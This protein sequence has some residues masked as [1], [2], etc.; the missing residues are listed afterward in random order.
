M[1]MYS[2]DPEN[3]VLAS[4]YPGANQDHLYEAAY[5]HRHKA[6]TICDTCST[7]LETCSMSCDELQ[8]HKDFLIQRQ[9]HAIQNI[10]GNPSGY[11]PSIHFGRFGSA[12]AVMRS[13]LDRD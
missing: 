13:G 9:R 12:N 6:D 10:I 11:T 2:R 4:R 5:I 1:L 3:N 8:C 7:G